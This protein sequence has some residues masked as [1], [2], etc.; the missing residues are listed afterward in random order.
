MKYRILQILIGICAMNRKATSKPMRAIMSKIVD[1]YNVRRGGFLDIH[2]KG[3]SFIYICA[4]HFQDYL[5]YFIFDEQMILNNPVE[6]WPLCHCLISFHST[7]FPLH[8]V[9]I[10]LFSIFKNLF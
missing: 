5:D 8:K 7:D 3:S 6:E 2:L 1:C 9:S 10:F 4:L